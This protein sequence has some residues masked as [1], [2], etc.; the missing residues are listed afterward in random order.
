MNNNLINQVVAALQQDGTCKMTADELAAILSPVA[1]SDGVR[2]KGVATPGLAPGGVAEPT[3]FVAVAGGRYPSFSNLQ[4]NEGQI[5][6]FGTDNGAAWEPLVAYSPS[7]SPT[8]T[9]GLRVIVSTADWGLISSEGVTANTKA[10]AAQ[11]AG[12]TE[13]DL[14]FLLD[15]G[16]LTPCLFVYRPVSQEDPNY[17]YQTEGTQIARLAEYTYFCMSSG[18]NPGIGYDVADGIYTIAGLGS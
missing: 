14:D 17:Y 9:S 5:V 13:D 4:V 16:D 15:G 3:I 18:N 6:F 11:I 2:F 1:I 12:I 10:E 8:P 7:P